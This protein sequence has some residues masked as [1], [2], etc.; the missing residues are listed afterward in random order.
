VE[1]ITAG[2]NGVD[3]ALPTGRDDRSGARATVT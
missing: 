2:R 1:S 3:S